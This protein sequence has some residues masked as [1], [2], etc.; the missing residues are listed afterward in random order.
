[1]ER[2]LA[3]IEEITGIRSI[4]GADKIEV[5]TVLGWE[6]IIGKEEF[7]VGDK[8]I[9]VEVDSIMPA[10]PEFEFLKPRKYRIKTIKLKKQISQGICFPLTILPKTTMGSILESVGDDVT[11]RLGVVKYDP[12]AAKEQSISSNPP[13]NFITKFLMRYKWYRKYKY[14]NEKIF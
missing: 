12:E 6:V 2:K 5:A 13:K 9:Y 3:H 4:P 8:I 7:K 11:E 1:M 14:C 10:L